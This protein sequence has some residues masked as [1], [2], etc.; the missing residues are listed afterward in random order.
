MVPLH[1]L[2]WRNIK[3][4]SINRPVCNTKGGKHCDSYK[5]RKIM[6]NKWSGFPREKF[7]SRRKTPLSFKE[8][9]SLKLNIPIMFASYPVPNKSKWV[10]KALPGNHS[11]CFLRY[12]GYA[13]KIMPILVPLKLCPVRLI[14]YVC[15]I[16]KGSVSMPHV[17]YGVTNGFIT[18][19]L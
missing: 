14:S 19:S 2:H 7:P 6:V 9:L 11:L 15:A 16:T 10:R 18:K 3:H 8:C 5:K 17:L 12:F 13:W 1:S 4:I